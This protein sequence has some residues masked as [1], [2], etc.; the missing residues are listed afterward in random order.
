MYKFKLRYGSSLIHEDRHVVGEEIIEA[1][2]FASAK[3]K[4]TTLMLAK[5]DANAPCASPER[6]L[7]GMDGRWDKPIGLK[8][9]KFST[10]WAGFTAELTAPCKAAL[11]S[12]PKK[13]AVAPKRRR[14]ED[15]AAYHKRVA[16]HTVPNRR[17][18]GGTVGFSTRD[19]ER[20]LREV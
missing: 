4:A 1:D 11:I 2:S 17:R 3:R 16:T 9:I 5:G 18:R 14:G 8:S 20:I 15:F 6:C 10:N 13:A 19:V 12:K 7:A